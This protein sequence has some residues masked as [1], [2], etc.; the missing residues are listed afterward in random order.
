MLWGY[1][2]VANGVANIT[3]PVVSGDFVFCTSSYGT[4]SA[5]LKIEK[6]GDKI[7]AK[8]VYF[9]KPREFENHHGG[10]VQVG[11]NIYGGHKRSQG[12][13]VS[14]KMGSGKINWGGRIR[15]IGGGSAAITFADGDLI[16]RY[17]DGTVALIAASDET[18][19]LKGYFKPK[20]QQGKSWAHPV[21]VNG[22]LYLREQNKL[23]CYD[24]RIASNN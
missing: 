17:E 2:Q 10:V 5:L 23:M 21:V 1:D 14:I 7:K 22:M 15:P 8:E 19:Q 13:P 20:F 6:E 9:L 18:Y 11:D 24:L 16:F 3:T 4:G 12:W